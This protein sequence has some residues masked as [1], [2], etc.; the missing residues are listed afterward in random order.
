MGKGRYIFR[1]LILAIAVLVGV[2]AVTFALARVVP[3]DPARKWVGARAR[4]EQVEQARIELGLDRPLYEQYA[5]Y[6]GQVLRGDLGTSVRSHRPILDDLRVY[7]PATLELVLASM[8]LSAL[9]GVPLGVLAAVR[10]DTALDR[11]CR[12]LAVLSV[13]TPV[14]WLALILQLAF[15]QWLDWLPLGGRVSREISL[16]APIQPLTGLYLV[17]AALTGNWR[18]FWD[19]VAHLVLP[20]V[21]LSS[22]GIGM[23]L[24]MTRANMVEVLGQKYILAARAAGLDRRTIHFKLALKNAILPSLVV[25]A[26]MFVWQMTGAVLVE[27]LFFWP[28]LGTYLMQAVLN[29]DF[30][31][32]VSVTLVVTVLY[33][34]A[35][36]VLDLVQAMIDP[37]VALE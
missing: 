8:A 20:A 5:R 34:L 29:I 36:L 32:I 37:R 19:A 22:Y 1:R 6:L 2:S 15:A 13:S 4:P 30:P 31:A 27:I 17:D 11:N 14:F 23:S 25:L 35:S 21:A 12:L 26:L 10:K 16:F 9:I 24:R 7:L 28:G 18:A 33:V 3:A